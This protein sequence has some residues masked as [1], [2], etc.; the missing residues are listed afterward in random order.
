MSRTYR[1]SAGTVSSSAAGK[2]KIILLPLPGVQADVAAACEEDGWRRSKGDPLVLT[3][4]EGD[5]TATVDLRAGEIT[6]RSSAEVEVFGEGYDRQDRQEVGEEL[7]R[8]DA[9]K[10]RGAFEEEAQRIASGAVIRA[11]GAVRDGV[12]KAISRG[13]VE[14]LKRRAAQ[15]GQVESVQQGTGANGAAEVTIKVRV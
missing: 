15:M 9:E 8:E 1:V 12:A 13:Y 6:I 5:A 7:A 3:R 11:E 14:A 4:Q 10:N 2:H